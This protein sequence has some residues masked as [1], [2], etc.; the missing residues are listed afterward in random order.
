MLRREYA[1]ADD[2]RKQEIEDQVHACIVPGD[3]LR[4]LSKDFNANGICLHARDLTKDCYIYERVKFNDW[5][6]KVKLFRNPSPLSLRDYLLQ[7]RSF[8]DR[9]MNFWKDEYKSKSVKSIVEDLIGDIIGRAS[10]KNFPCADPRQ[11]VYNF[12]NGV[13]VIEDGELSFVHDEWIC[14]LFFFDFC[15]DPDDSVIPYFD[16]IFADQGVNEERKRYTMAQF[17]RL[18]TSQ[19]KSHL[20]PHPPL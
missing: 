18:L 15:Y 10:M 7:W 17:G 2:D 12:R 1:T 8:S 3:P 13:L 16:K 9:T 20:P 11:D 19:G 4:T 14:G 6:V 5:C